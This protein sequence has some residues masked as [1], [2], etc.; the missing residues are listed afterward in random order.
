MRVGAR[1]H[2]REER[3]SDHPRS[4]CPVIAAYLRTYNDR[5]DDD[6]RQ[7]LYEYAA[8][9][10]D[11]RSTRTVEQE[12]AELCLSWRYELTAREPFAES[13]RR[14][15]RSRRLWVAHEA[16]LAAARSTMPDAHWQALALID[17]MLDVGR[18]RPRGEGNRHARSGEPA[19]APIVPRGSSA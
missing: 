13:R 16:A 14:L 18:R 10:V 8:R 2:A 6:R 5:I 15:G 1:F 17:R 12:R 19:R 3:F 7:D 9:V 4:V 11:S